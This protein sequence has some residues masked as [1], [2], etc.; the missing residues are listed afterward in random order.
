MSNCVPKGGRKGFH[1]LLGHASFEVQQNNT[2]GHHPWDPAIKTKYSSCVLKA[3]EHIKAVPCS[4][5]LHIRLEA[6]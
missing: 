5:H 3:S 6:S 2:P 1:L 4:L